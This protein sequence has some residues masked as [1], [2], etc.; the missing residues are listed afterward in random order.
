MFKALRFLVLAVSLAGCAAASAGLAVSRVD[1]INAAFPL[2]E[3]LITSQRL[4]EAELRSS[5]D[6]HFMKNDYAEL[7]AAR[8]LRCAG[9]IE[10]GPFET[11]AAIRSKIPDR[12]CFTARDVELLDWVGT[13][14]V[15]LALRKPPLTP[16]ERLPDRALLPL[17]QGIADASGSAPTPVDLPSAAGSQREIHDV[18]VSS[19]SNVGVL[20]SRNGTL[21]VMRLPEGSVINSFRAP[22]NS[23]SAGLISANGRVAAVPLIGATAMLDLESGNTLWSSTQY[24]ALIAWL[25]DLQAALLLQKGTGKPFIF[26]ERTA[27]FQPYVGPIALPIWAVAVPGKPGRYVMGDSSWVAVVDHARRPDG[28]LEATLVKRLRLTGSL[29]ASIAWRGSGGERPPPFIMAGGKMLVYK[30]SKEELAWLDLEIGQQGKWA[31]GALQMRGYAQVSDTEVYVNVYGGK[32]TQGYYLF[33][34]EQRTL[35]ATQ[36]INRTDGILQPLATNRGYLVRA[37]GSLTIGSRVIPLGD[38][39]PL[40]TMMS[41]AAVEQERAAAAAVAARAADIIA[42]RSP[43]V[44][45]RWPG[46]Q[47]LGVPSSPVPGVPANAHVSV[48][49]VYESENLDLKSELIDVSLQPSKVPVVLVLS[50]YESVHWNIRTN[51]RPIAAVLLSGYK[52][53]K[54]SGYEGKIVEIGQSYAIAADSREYQQLRA[55]IGEHVA[56]PVRL[57]QG[58]YSASAFSVPAD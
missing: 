6:M 41:E 23:W 56:Q 45:T 1:K 10:V 33:D 44:V 51:G 35:T 46:T 38:P 43:V 5:P 14:R 15:A 3:E 28:A 7:L 31:N 36:A 22:P 29:I 18:A 54:V 8:A 27:G 49:G 4:F 25:P 21:T 50:S 26:D 52:K 34:I 53:S 11:E 42:R 12:S 30:S 55:A 17:P 57:F 24:A 9:N 39:R 47:A 40:E 32:T 37:S 16:F 20:L 19:G 58:T 2:A 13:R 48:I